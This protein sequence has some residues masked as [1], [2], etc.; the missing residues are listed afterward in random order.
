MV[1][2]YQNQQ[3]EE[4]NMSYV[5]LYSD[6]ILDTVNIGK[7]NVN[8]NPSSGDYIKVQIYTHYN[9]YVNCVLG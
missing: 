1:E 7:S 2:H 3:G 4:D 9:R 5:E 6:D 8:F